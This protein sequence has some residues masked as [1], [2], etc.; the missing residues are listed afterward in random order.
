MQNAETEI[1]LRNR[2]HYIRTVICSYRDYGGSLPCS[3]CQDADGLARGDRSAGRR[4]R[5]QNG[6][7]Y[8]G[9]PLLQVPQSG[10]YRRRSQRRA[11]LAGDCERMKA[12][13]DSGI[14]EE[15][16]RIIVSYLASQMGQKGSFAAASL[17][18]ARAVVDQRCGRCHSLDRVYKTAET[19]EEWRATVYRMVAFCPGQRQRISARRRRTDHRLLVRDANPRCRQPAEGSGDGGFILRPEHGNANR[20]RGRRSACA[21]QPV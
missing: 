20:R 1:P 21:A 3:S 15:E 14:S 9:E 12:L 19:P 18:V 2:T 13:P 4:Y 7:L 17:E 16:A 10:L 6:G 11:G 5:S 8:Y